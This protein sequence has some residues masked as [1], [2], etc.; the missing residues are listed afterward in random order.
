[1]GNIDGISKQLF[2]LW[3]AGNAQAQGKVY[4]IL[5][6]KFLYVAHSI[7]RDQE[8]AQH[9]CNDAFWKLDEQAQA[10]QLHW[11]GE[12]PLCAYVRRAVYQASLDL[13]RTLHSGDARYEEQH[14]V[15]GPRDDESNIEYVEQVAVENWLARWQ[16]EEMRNAQAQTLQQAIAE[17]FKENPSDRD[18]QLWEAC[19]AWANTPGG[20][21]W[22]PHQI[23]AFLK[24]QLAG[25]GLSDSAFYTALSRLKVKM[26]QFRNQRSAK[27]T[28]SD[29]ESDVQRA[30]FSQ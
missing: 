1:M 24:A 19:L 16:E 17:Y 9:V 25:L 4:A 21:Q 29:C 23:S 2:G 3:R 27:P 30:R 13:Y 12:G 5:T 28:R 22:S 26:T 11:Q 8:Y 10:G 6:R 20:D 15:Y 7:L 14:R 18:R